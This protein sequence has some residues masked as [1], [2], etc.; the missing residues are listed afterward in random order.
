MTLK[1]IFKLIL[2]RIYIIVAVPLIAVIATIVV[3][4]NF[5]DPSYTASTTIYV[6]N[7]TEES[8]TQQDLNASLA[9]TS[10]YQEIAMSYA[11]LDAVALEFGYPDKA[12][13]REDYDV[14]V[15]PISDTRIMKISVT[16]KNRELVDDVANSIGH[17]FKINAMKIMDLD[18]IE[19]VD[20]AQE[21]TEPSAPNKIAS[22]I[23]AAVV[24]F[25]LTLAIV[26]L[27]EVLNTT[28]RTPEDVE[29]V[30]GLPILAKIPKMEEVE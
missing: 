20:K 29:N 14:A 1:Q 21:Q 3:V 13:L 8:L 4:F 10:D 6:L 12:H 28:I 27:V 26:L 9:L 23:I 22:V 30:L 18:N 15:A 25:V 19:V 16:G 7:K 2:D 24:A 5:V 11:V 17:H